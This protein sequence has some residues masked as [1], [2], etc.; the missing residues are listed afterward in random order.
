MSTPLS[1]ISTHTHHPYHPKDPLPHL[2]NQNPTLSPRLTRSVRGNFL[3]V[4]ILTGA[5]RTCH[6]FKLSYTID[7]LACSGTSCSA[8]C[9]KF[10]RLICIIL[11]SLSVILRW[12]HPTMIA[13]PSG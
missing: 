8:T 7:L 3:D 4:H 12:A 1:V 6:H 13:A 2:R 11:I 10:S 5:P 9:L